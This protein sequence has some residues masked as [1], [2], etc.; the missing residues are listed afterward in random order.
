MSRSYK[1]HNYSSYVKNCNDKWDRTCYQRQLRAKNRTLLRNCEVY[2]SDC[3]LYSFTKCELIDEGVCEALEYECP[4]CRFS[5]NYN[6]NNYI[7]DDDFI[8]GIDR[9]VSHSDIWI[10][11]SDGGKYYQESVEKIIKEE[12]DKYIV[13]D[14]LYGYYYAKTDIWKSYTEY[15]Q[16]KYKYSSFDCL[17]TLFKYNKVPK[18]FQSREML[19]DWL[20]DNKSNIIKFYFKMLLRR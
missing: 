9:T 20:L 6:L 3:Q 8:N 19:N 7:P 17:Y 5:D 12:Y 14:V 4:L 1:K 2:Y 18:N 13:N 15:Q 16:G 11:D 10:W